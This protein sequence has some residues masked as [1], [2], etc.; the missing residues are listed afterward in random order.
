MKNVATEDTPTRAHRFV[1]LICFQ[2]TNSY[3]KFSLLLSKQEMF[4]QALH[5]LEGFLKLNVPGSFLNGY[6][7]AYRRCMFVA[8]RL[9]SA[10]RETV[11]LFF[12][13]LVRR[14]RVL[15]NPVIFFA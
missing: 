10:S 12:E 9:L 8:Y 3:R 13:K 1:L 11:L 7:Y 2:W 6:F 4:V 5:P 15:P 14:F